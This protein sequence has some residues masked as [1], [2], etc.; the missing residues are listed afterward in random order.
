MRTLL[1]IL[2][3]V[4]MILG[5]LSSLLSIVGA[6]AAIGVAH[7]SGGA[8]IALLL[9]NGFGSLARF[10]ECLAVGLG[11]LFLLDVDRR[12]RSGVAPEV[13]R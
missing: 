7:A 1:A 13:F 8:M 6:L 3:W 2:A 12:L 4:V 10:V 9:N 11:L 5:A